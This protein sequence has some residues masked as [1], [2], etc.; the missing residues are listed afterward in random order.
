[1]H[2]LKTIEEQWATLACFVLEAGVAGGDA[3]PWARGSWLLKEGDRGQEAS[4]A[5][6]FSL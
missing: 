2:D 5:L 3:L 4:T 6:Y 1:M